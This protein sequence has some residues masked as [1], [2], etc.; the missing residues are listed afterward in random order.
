MRRGALCGQPGGN[1]FVGLT[2]ML[3]ICIAG[4]DDYGLSA[5]AGWIPHSHLGPTHI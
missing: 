3:E 2:R 5:E 1:V 4:H